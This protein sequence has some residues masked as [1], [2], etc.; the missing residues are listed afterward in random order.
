MKNIILGHKHERDELLRQ[1]FVPREGIEHARN[2]LE[3]NLIKVIVGPRRAGKSVFALQML[4][5]ADFAYL[6][7]DDERLVGVGDY[8]EILKSLIE[9]YG[10]IRFLLFDEIQNLDKWELFVNRLQRRGFRILL[11]GSNSRLLSME[12]S[13]HLTGRYLQFQVLPFSFTEYLQAKDFPVDD[14][15]N[16]KERQGMILNHLNAY[17]LTGGFP[18]VV[19]TQVD[20]QGYLKTL[21]DGILFKDIVK[22]YNI[23]QPKRLYDLGL[24]VLT[25][26]ANEFSYNRLKNYLG[27]KSVSTVENYLGYLKEAF[28]AF[29]IRKF[30]FKVKENMK[31]PGKVYGYDTGMIHAVKFRTS[32]DRGRLLENLV[33]LELLRRTNDFYYYKT[34]DNREVDFVVKK[35]LKIKQLIQVCHDWSPDD[36][37]KKREL[38]AITKASSDLECDN[39]MVLTWDLQGEEIVRTRKVRFVPV[40]AWMLSSL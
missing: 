15:I 20:Q 33:A 40:W 22:R 13:S 14:A 36:K 12:L 11:T 19:V 21:F 31:S 3:N 24:Y 10:E 17:M 25:N 4:H 34:A 32:P 18:E 6:N 26:H 27:F 16:L 30:S 35:G 38:T 1:N 29:D 37:T 9:V 2:N 7:F 8:D 23:R 39:L 5:G 28:L